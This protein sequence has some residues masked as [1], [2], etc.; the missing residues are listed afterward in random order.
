VK[1]A[2]FSRLCRPPSLLVVLLLAGVLAQADDAAPVLTYHSNSSEVRVTFFLTDARNQRVES[3]TPDDF[4]V[5]DGEMVVRNFRSLARTDET[6]LDV[7]ILID[8]SESVAKNFSGM[9]DHV[10]D[11]ISQRQVA[12]DDKLAVIAFGGLEPRMVCSGNCRTQAASQRV[13]SLKPSGSTP[14]FDAMQYAANLILQRTQPGVR[15]VLI[16]FS[17][18]E[19]TIS[20]ASA[21]EALQSVIETGAVIYG[22]DLSATDGRDGSAA[23]RRLAEATGGMT[24]SLEASAGVLED[25]FMDLR[26]SYVVTYQLPSYTAGFH[27]VRILP[28]HDPNLRFHCR[29]GYYYGEIQ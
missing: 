16:L 2:M 26:N 17:D 13:L 8:A 24:F 4:V 23:L 21:K 3:I 25:A 20:K 10:W 9:I 12:D 5:V 1:Y 6:A 22:V 7:V 15:P 11:L 27:P 18:G 28:K 19:D 14:L 29:S